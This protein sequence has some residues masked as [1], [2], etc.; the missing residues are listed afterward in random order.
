MFDI[1][2]QAPFEIEETESKDYTIVKG[3]LL[4]A[5]FTGN[6]H[7]YS[8]AEV[9][10]IAKDLVGKPVRFG[11]S[12]IGKHFKTKAYEVGKVLETWID[13]AKKRIL[14]RV[15]IWNTSKVPQIVETIKYYGS[16]MGFSIGGKASRLDPILKNGLPQLISTG[17]GI[18]ARIIGMKVKHLQ[19]IPPETP[20]GQESAKVEEVE[21][22]LWVNP[23]IAPSGLSRNQLIAVIV[24]TM[25]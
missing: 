21:E 23:E 9:K 3:T 24:S 12:R 15:K 17:H 11:S 19:I 16:R 4:S 5:G 6:G 25:A 8:F 22:T 20:R 10:R 7:F 2:F 1:T 13:S 18:L 14:G